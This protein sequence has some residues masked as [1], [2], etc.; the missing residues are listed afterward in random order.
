MRPITKLFIF[1]TLLALSACDTK[2]ETGA[3]QT[4]SAASIKTQSYDAIVDANS[5]AAFSTIQAAL[6]AAPTD[7]TTHHRIL[8]KAGRYK[9]KLNITRGNLE[10][11]G[12]GAAN[13]VIYFDAYAGNSRGYRADNWGTPGSATMSI[14]AVDVHIA[15]LTIENTFDFLANDIKAEDDPTKA[16]DSQAVALLLDT[17]SDKISLSR[18]TLNGYQDTLFVHGYRAY[19]YESTISGNVDFI[20]G[21]GNAVFD[22]STIVSRPRNSTFA[23]GEI[24]SFITAPS[25]N[26]AREYGLTFLD[27][28]LTREEGVP[29]QSITLGRPWHPTT[30]FPDGR[31]AD[32]DAIGKAV[33]IRTF[34]D[35]HIN[36]QGW[37]SM[38]GTAPDGTKSRIFTP[39]ESRFF[40]YKSAGPGAV[41]NPQRPQ[42]T[43]AQAADYSL[44]TILAGWQPLR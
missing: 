41:I 24:H 10:I 7:A 18:V 25:T 35:S 28:T 42:L 6:D 19:F 1:L 4:M 21:Q 33:F 30:T 29:D 13:T 38:A 17:G 14:D 12:E 37:S 9:E 36:T 3:T 15:D 16:A 39:E 44:E 23:E 8:I 43:D 32:P 34:M 27:C 22:R 5:P 31:Y 40:E 26:I 11:K 2:P 20:F